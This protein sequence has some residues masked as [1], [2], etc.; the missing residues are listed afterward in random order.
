MSNERTGPPEPAASP[1]DHVER[2][3]TKGNCYFAALEFLKD[4]PS[5]VG[6]FP[7]LPQGAVVQLAHGRL[8]LPAR[9]PL[10]HA[11]VEIN[12]S[13][14]LDN[15]N[16]RSWRGTKDEYYQLHGVVVA[17]RFT[18]ELA[19]AIL[20]YRR[21]DD[22]EL[23]IAYWGDLS[24][25]YIHKCLEA[26]NPADSVFSAGTVFSDPNDTSNRDNLAL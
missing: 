22:G 2:D 13:V 10:E 8:H 9:E 21:N 23:M 1:L 25:A 4:S 19:D 7:L 12:D 16:N 6:K 3:W 26:Y 24:D 15:A 5:L 17:R 20:S 14:V 11:W 18:R